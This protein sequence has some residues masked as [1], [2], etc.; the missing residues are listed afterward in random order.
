MDRQM[1]YVRCH[2]MIYMHNLF[3]D[4][5]GP[6]NPS[7]FPVKPRELRESVDILGDIQLTLL[8]EAFQKIWLE[9]KDEY[10]TWGRD[11]L[12]EFQIEDLSR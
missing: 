9:D 3:K 12:I 1:V 4:K 7:E 8:P 11:K 10:I 6:L 2:R 5:V